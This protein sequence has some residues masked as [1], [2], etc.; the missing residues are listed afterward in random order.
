M[1]DCIVI[2][3]WDTYVVAHLCLSA[4]IMHALATDDDTLTLPL[5][6]IVRPFVLDD[7]GRMKEPC[8]RSTDC[9]NTTL[10]PQYHG[11]SFC[12]DGGGLW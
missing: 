12:G 1:E 8:K 5:L 10:L 4:D 7:S 6:P 2:N 11:G 3:F 9:S